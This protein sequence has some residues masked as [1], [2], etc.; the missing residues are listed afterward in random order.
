[1]NLNVEYLA[2]ILNSV[3]DDVTKLARFNFNLTLGRRGLKLRKVHKL[4]TA[5]S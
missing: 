2:T 5:L 1:M 4:L 3:Y